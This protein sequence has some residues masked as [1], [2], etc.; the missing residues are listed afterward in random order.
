M[1]ML[2]IGP[3]SLVLSLAINAALS[4]LTGLSLTLLPEQFAAFLSLKFPEVLRLFGIFLLLHGGILLLVC[5][6]SKASM[7][8][9][10]ILLL[11]APY[12]LVLAALTAVS[13]FGS[14]SAS[15]LALADAIAV[16]VIALWQFTAWQKV[17]NGENI[18]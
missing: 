3:Q 10:L 18:Q 1:S 16:A 11:I 12:P 17:R 14:A 6:T 15:L 4:F 7:W 2:N 8:V 13:F 9:G 5:R